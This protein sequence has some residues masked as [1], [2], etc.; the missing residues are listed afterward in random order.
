[1]NKQ[2][3]GFS[4]DLL[5]VIL[6]QY[7]DA[8]K[9]QQLLSQK[10]HWYNDNQ[11]GF[12]QDWIKDVFDLNTANDFGLAVWATILDVPILLELPVSNTDINAF[13]FGDN[14][15]NFGHSC[16]IRADIASIRLATEQKRIIL[17]LRYFQ[18]TSKG[19]VPEINQCI[20]TVFGGGHVIDSYDMA[21]SIYVLNGEVDASFKFI[22][23][24]L[25]LLPRPAG[26]GTE[27]RYVPNTTLFGFGWNYQNF[28]NSNFIST[29]N[30]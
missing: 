18:L 2:H 27:I 12:W 1:M 8:E 30:L 21:Y 7:N 19:S 14:Y 3:F 13:G 20:K 24:H 4:V 26:V 5:K 10:Q 6:W 11:A 28:E 9:L 16:F 15:Q 17:K 22:I 23:D 29:S 25:D